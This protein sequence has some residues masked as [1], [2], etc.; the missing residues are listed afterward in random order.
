VLLHAEQA[1]G[2]GTTVCTSVLLSLQAF[3]HS[4]AH[5]LGE[6]L[7]QLYGVDLT[8]GPTIEEG[9]YY[10]CYMGEGR[11]TLSQEELTQVEGKMESIVS[12]AQPFQRVEITKEE[13]LEM[14]QEN[15]FKV[16]HCW[17]SSVQP[18]NSCGW[19]GWWTEAHS[20]A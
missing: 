17:C 4:S 19:S 20:N 15:R 7:E 3:W 16:S 12:E 6:S 2:S 5:I 9:F 14:F 13:A 1:Q 11:G 18:W 10:D 8:I